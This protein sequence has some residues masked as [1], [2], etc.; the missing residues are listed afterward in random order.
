ML[1][2]YESLIENCLGQLA[3]GNDSARQAV[4]ELASERLYR[5]SRVMFHRFPALRNWEE[6]PDIHQ[7]A[8]LRL[9]HALGDVRPETT[10]QLFN[11]AALQV[12]RILIDLARHYSATHEGAQRHPIPVSF[13]PG[14]LEHLDQQRQDSSLQPGSLENWTLFHE[15]IG[16]LPSAEREVAML[17]FYDGLSQQEVADLMEISMRTVKRLWQSAKMTLR[18]SMDHPDEP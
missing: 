3:T 17:L 9:F 5:L 15:K 18:R 11:L 16:T 6:T 7:R 10:R 14:A 4:L 13:Q 12:K 8:M 1:G 2:N